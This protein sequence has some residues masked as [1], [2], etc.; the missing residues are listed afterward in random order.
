MSE[1]V[2]ERSA[3]FGFF[4]ARIWNMERFYN[5]ERDDQILLHTDKEDFVGFEPSL[6][7]VQ[8]S[9]PLITERASE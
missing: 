5:G 4:I 3:L 1:S 9:A 7:N 2:S 8:S 6:G